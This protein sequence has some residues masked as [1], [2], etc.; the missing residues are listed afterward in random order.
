MFLL[1]IIIIAITTGILVFL[2]LNRSDKAAQQKQQLEKAGNA[3]VVTRDLY[4]KRETRLFDIIENKFDPKYTREI[5]E[6]EVTVGMPAEFL[7][8]AWGHPAEIRA[9]DGKENHDETW[10]YPQEKNS[11]EPSRFTEVQ[12]L[13][14]KVLGWKDN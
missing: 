9:G 8:M 11:R 6:G 7:L 10:M 12:I 4:E 2:L 1:P 3:L 5:R 14:R 13:N